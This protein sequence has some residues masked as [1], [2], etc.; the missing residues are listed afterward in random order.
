MST[1]RIHLKKKV[2][3]SA[4]VCRAQALDMAH[5]IRANVHK[6]LRYTILEEQASLCRVRAEA[7]LLGMKQVD[8]L[9]LTAN[10]DGSVSQR[11]VGGA[12]QGLCVTFRFE[13][14]GES[15]WILVTAEAPVRGIKRILKPL[16]AIAL[17]KLGEQALE[18]DRADLEE[19]NYQPSELRAAS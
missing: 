9:E 1:I 5:H 15:S 19:G 6:E 17:R 4:A 14:A 13:P 3:R 18:E 11:Y 7:R 2:R 16:L 12:N 8:E 10:K